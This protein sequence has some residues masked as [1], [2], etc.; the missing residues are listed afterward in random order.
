MSNY[1]KD[2]PADRNRKTL[3]LLRALYK[4]PR[5][6]PPQK[7][8]VGQLGKLISQ[9]PN[10]DPK[11]ILSESQAKILRYWAYTHEV[12]LR[13]TLPKLPGGMD[14]KMEV[15][16][17]LKDKI[18]VTTQIK[19]SRKVAEQEI[20]DS[21]NLDHLGMGVIDDIKTKFLREGF[22]RDGNVYYVYDVNVIGW[23]VDSYEPDYEGGRTVPQPE[24]QSYQGEVTVYLDSRYE[25]VHVEWAGL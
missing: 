25:P 8:L 7:S 9:S 10:K 21:A 11:N 12:Y 4:A 23:S 6:T 5:I 1:Y 18:D 22:S 16:R 3:G 14:F 17:L 19:I 2:T 20:M 13:N 15:R 24:R